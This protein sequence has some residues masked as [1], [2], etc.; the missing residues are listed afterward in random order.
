MLDILLS[1]FSCFD[2]HVYFG[3]VCTGQI[4][5][6]A[7]DVFVFL[8]LICFVIVCLNDCGLY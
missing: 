6:G 1:F 8:L 2:C 7:V 3:L 4:G 5:S